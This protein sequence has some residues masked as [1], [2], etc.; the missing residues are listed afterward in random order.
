MMSYYQASSTIRG[1]QKHAAECVAVES[2]LSIGQDSHGKP[3]SPRQAPVTVEMLPVT[4]GSLGEFW[5]DQH[6]PTPPPS[7][8][9][10]LSPQQGEPEDSCDTASDI[11]DSPQSRTSTVAPTKGPT[12]SLKRKSRLAQVGRYFSASNIYNCINWLIKL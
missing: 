8:A 6:P 12:I 10:S 11:L 4:R 3:P 7:D 1:H 2:L 5:S 9:G